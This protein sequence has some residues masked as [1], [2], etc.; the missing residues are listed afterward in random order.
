LVNIGVLTHED[1]RNY[2]LTGVMS[3]SVGIK[4]DLRLDRKNTYANYS[5]LNIKSYCGHNGDSYDRF[6]IRMLEMGESLNIIN[7]VSTTLLTNFLKNG[8]FLYSN[9]LLNKIFYNKNEKKYT[10]MEDLIEHFIN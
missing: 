8:D 6:L 3:R 10:S 1:C 7:N 4:R 5:R 2:N 9:L